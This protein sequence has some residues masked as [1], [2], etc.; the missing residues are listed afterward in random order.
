MSD[1][2]TSGPAHPD[3]LPR[4][5]R[6]RRL[7]LTTMTNRGIARRREEDLTE[8]LG[9]DAGYLMSDYITASTSEVAAQLLLTEHLLDNGWDWSKIL[10]SVW[11]R[12]EAL[13]EAATRD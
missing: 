10:K 6:A 2:A 1:L 5:R 7:A 3:S 12:E 8:Y 9:E 11:Y 13:R 4:D